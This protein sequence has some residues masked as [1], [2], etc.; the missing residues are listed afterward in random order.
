MKHSKFSL[1]GIII[2]GLGILLSLIFILFSTWRYFFVYVDINIGI[3]GLI[4]GAIGICVGVLIMS[5]S[6]LY[7]QHLINGIRVQSL[8]DFIQDIDDVRRQRDS[9]I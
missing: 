4:V 5:V 9:G 3:I 8:E 6:W 2:G 7:E 1:I